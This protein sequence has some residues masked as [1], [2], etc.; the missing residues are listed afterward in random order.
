MYEDINI[1]KVYI[2]S[3]GGR[4]PRM[5]VYYA[6]DKSGAH[7]PAIPQPRKIACMVAHAEVGRRGNHWLA[8]AIFHNEKESYSGK[9]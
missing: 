2:C 6:R 3:V 8:R 4:G 5:T 7:C 9:I 1:R